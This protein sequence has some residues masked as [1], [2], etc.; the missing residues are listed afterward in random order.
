MDNGVQHERRAFPKGPDGLCRDCK[1]SRAYL[2]AGNALRVAEILLVGGLPVL[3]TWLEARGVFHINP[4][5]VTLYIGGVCVLTAASYGWRFKFAQPPSP[6][7]D[8]ASP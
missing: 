6:P 8:P 7:S 1:H 4:E 2:Q 3:W 5:W